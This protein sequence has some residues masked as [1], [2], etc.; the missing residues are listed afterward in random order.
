MKSVDRARR[1]VVCFFFYN[2][3][4]FVI[5]STILYRYNRIGALFVRRSGN[6]NISITRGVWVIVFRRNTNGR[7]TYYLYT[8]LYT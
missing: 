5:N 3:Y 6:N 4:H 8:H 2:L 1:R 7:Y